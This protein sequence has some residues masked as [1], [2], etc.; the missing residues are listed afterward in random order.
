MCAQQ[1]IRCRGGFGTSARVGRVTAKIDAATSKTTQRD[2]AVITMLK[3]T[4]HR[5][6]S[7]RRRCAFGKIE[8]MRES[9][10]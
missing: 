8:F 1:L 9:S 10:G 7:T 2:N 5:Y 6:E 4:L 3:L